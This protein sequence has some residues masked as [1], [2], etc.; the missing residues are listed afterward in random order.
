VEQ[1]F[2]KDLDFKKEVCHAG[3]PVEKLSGLLFAYLGPPEKKPLLPRWDLLVR[4]DGTRRIAVHPVLDCNWLQCQENSVDPTHTYYLHA[5]NMKLKG[6]RQGA[7]HDRPIEKIEFEVFEWGIV[8]KRTF[9][10]SD[11]ESGHP[12][13]F[14]NML[15]TYKSMHF[16]VP[17]DETHT[18]IFVVDFYP[19][20]GGK[21]SQ[22][23]Q[24]P[25]VEYVNVKNDKGEFHMESFNSQDEMA[26]E[27]QGSIFDR[28]KEN[29]G[30]SDR[31]ITLFRRIL[32]DQ[33]RIV[34]EGG[35]PMALVRDPEK[36]RI[37][38]FLTEQE[39]W[40]YAAEAR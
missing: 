37:I 33:I 2:E 6:L 36:N 18:Q 28:S 19:A 27:T 4:E 3:Y 16:R 9:A 24:D 1:P 23:I 7:Y 31:G 38:E 8:K 21:K 39:K 20:E 32:R 17:I 11:P 13:V 29:L 5:H 10:G 35:D 34:Q 14:P 26:W 30:E 22:E 15:R 12:L 40:S 25:P